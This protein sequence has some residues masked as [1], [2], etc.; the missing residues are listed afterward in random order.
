MTVDDCQKWCHSFKHAST[1]WSIKCDWN[2]CKGCNSCKGDELPAV[3]FKEVTLEINLPSN[4]WDGDDMMH[5]FRPGS[6]HFAAS[7]PDWDNDG[8][9][10][11]FHSNH[12]RMDYA[13]DFDF[14][15]SRPAN[16]GIGRTFHSIGHSSFVDTDELKIFHDCHGSTFADMDGDGLLDLLISVG[17]EG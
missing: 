16:N 1:P 7:F 8:N 9:L 3:F 5:S 14:G 2:A 11:Y 13:A 10:D 15:L 17:G 12:F 4:D 6:H